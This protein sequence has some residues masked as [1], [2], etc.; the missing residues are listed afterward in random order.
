[1][2]RIGVIVFICLAFGGLAFGQEAPTRPAPEPQPV[3][4]APEVVTRDDRGHAILRAVRLPG[5]FQLDGRLDEPFYTSVKGAGGF[6]Q[7]EPLEGQPA[8]D[9]TDVWVFFDDKN[10]YVSARMC[11]TDPAKR[12]TTD[13]RRDSN[14]LYNNDHIA[15]M[16]D[17][18]NDHRNAF[19]V[20][21]NAQGG[22]FDWQVDQRA[23]E[24]ELERSVGSAD[25]RLRRTAGPSSS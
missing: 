9:Q 5:P 19:G 20:S 18:F 21:S 11:E 16:F 8:T 10:I 13:M 17:T 22:M 14:N 24:P 12:V 25:G 4:S 15:V 3:P 23:T 1:M 2:Y 7:Q 6:L